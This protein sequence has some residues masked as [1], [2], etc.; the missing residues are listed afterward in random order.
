MRRVLAGLWA[1]LPLA[2]LLLTLPWTARGGGAAVD[3][4][5][6]QTGLTAT[7]MAALA[8]AGVALLS[9][10]VPAGWGRWGLAAASALGWGGYA[11]PLLGAVAPGL[12]WTVVGVAAVLAGWV[13]HRLHGSRALPRDQLLRRVPERA[14]VQ[15][16]RGRAVAPVPVWTSDVASGTLRVQGLVLLAVFG[17]T[18]VVVLLLGEGVLL[19]LGVLLFGLAGGGLALA[20]SRVTLRVDEDGL[21]VRSGVLSARLLRVPAGDV[22]GVEV[23]DL[24]PMA[25][26]GIGL[27]PL[28]DRTSYVVDAGPGLVVWRSDGRR[29]A[30]QVTEGD[31]A[32]R[33]G[34]RALAQAAGQRLGVATGS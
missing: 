4:G 2:L 10:V 16:L 18:A 1:M 12:R 17:L 21:Q 3:V 22:V 8:A 24:D 28:P 29:L 14:R 31:R 26:G 20:W 5:L 7:V 9:R 11:V 32:A 25:W 27:R 33:A 23:L 30:V 13:G 6:L 34:A 15:A 19:T